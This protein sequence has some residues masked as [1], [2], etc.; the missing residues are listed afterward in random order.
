M[1]DAHEFLSCVLDQLRSLSVDLRSAAVDM[2]VRYTCPVN[3]HIAFQMLSTRTCKGYEYAAT[4][5]CG[6]K[7][8][9]QDV[10][11]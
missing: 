6:R 9:S 3:A 8:L 11:F 10:L 7:P 1:Q 5:S 2:G 4:D